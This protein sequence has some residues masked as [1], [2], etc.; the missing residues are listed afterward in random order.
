MMAVLRDTITLISENYG[1]ELGL[2]QIPID[3]PDVYTT[4]QNADTIGMFQVESRAQIAFLPKSKPK[5]FYDIVVQVAIIRPGP[6][7][8]NMLSA[9]INRRQGKEP[10]T[11]SASVAQ[12]D[13]RADD[14]RAAVSGTTAKDRNGHRGF[15]GKSRPRN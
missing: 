14:G 11:I 12:A 4:L 9:Y 3:D 13:I 15:Y 2:Y 10:V 7:V 1:E 5:T 6:V 8:G